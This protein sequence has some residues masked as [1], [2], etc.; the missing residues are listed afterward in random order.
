MELILAIVGPLLGGII[1]ISVWQTKK[2]SQN[3]KDQFQSMHECVHQIDVKLD[4]LTL[5]VAKCYVSRDEMMEK[6]DNV[7]YRIKA[8]LLDKD[9]RN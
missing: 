3:I 1:S 4:N 9:T 5:D 8:E 2:N 7:Q 6:L